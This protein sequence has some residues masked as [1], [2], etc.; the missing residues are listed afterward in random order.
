MCGEDGLN[1][2]TTKMTHVEPV[3]LSE[4]YDLGFC[5]EKIPRSFVL[6]RRLSCNFPNNKIPTIFPL[7][8]DIAHQAPPAIYR[9]YRHSHSKTTPPPA[10]LYIAAIH[11]A[12]LEKH[13]AKLGAYSFSC[14]PF[15][16]SEAC[17]SCQKP[18][19]L[20]AFPCVFVCYSI[21]TA[22]RTVVK[23]V[24]QNTELV[25][26]LYCPAAREAVYS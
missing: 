17:A 5:V 13:Y 21:C 19:Y 2:E 26:C 23:A 3:Q 14:S 1:F 16:G 22:E 15:L 12:R 6:V 11:R 4:K 8:S 25:L 7:E 24:T 18:E 10:T 9:T 20:R